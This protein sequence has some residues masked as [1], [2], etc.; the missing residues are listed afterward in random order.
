MK[1]QSILCTVQV[2]T[3]N[4]MPGI[5]RCLDSLRAFAEVIVQDG[6]STDGTRELLQEYPNV[7]LVEQNPCYLNAEG[8][9]T[10]FAAMRNESIS[11]AR[12]D[13]I[14]VVDG[15]ERVDS[16]LIAEV[17]RIVQEGK[18]GVYQ[19]FRRFYLGERPVVFCSG[20]PALQIRLFHRGCIEGYVKPVH[21]RLN[22]KPGCQTQLLKAELPVP[23]PPVEDLLPKYERYLRMEIRR[24]GIISWGRWI[25]WVLLRN[26]RSIIGL[27]VRILW[28]RLLPCRGLRM[29][30]R[31]EL[32]YLRHSWRTIVYACPP[33]AA[34]L[35]KKEDAASQTS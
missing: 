11:A 31:Y 19:A 13:W 25:R 29:P 10:D 7:R 16:T 26:L 18:P 6:G 5:R 8:R 4:S 23:L 22:L 35:L 12:Y 30:L 28:L 20:Y 32:P 14:F 34:Q 3:R 9:I 1:E 15:D 24:I 27:A 21:E 2:L 33:V 17:D